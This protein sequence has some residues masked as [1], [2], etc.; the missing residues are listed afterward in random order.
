[1]I[2]AEDTPE[3]IDSDEKFTI[4]RPQENSIDLEMPPSKSPPKI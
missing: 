3:K 4:E 2:E 1:M